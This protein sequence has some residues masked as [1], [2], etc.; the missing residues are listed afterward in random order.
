MEWDYDCKIMEQFNLKKHIIYKI[1]RIVLREGAL[2]I[3]LAKYFPVF[4]EMSL[5][6]ITCLFPYNNGRGS[7]C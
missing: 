4:F 2:I 7:S 6:I 1:I 3:S 5:H